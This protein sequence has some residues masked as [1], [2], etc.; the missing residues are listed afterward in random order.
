MAKRKNFEIRLNG[1]LLATKH[2]WNASKRE[3]EKLVKQVAIKNGAT[4]YNRGMC[5]LEQD[6][7]KCF[8]KGYYLW[9]CAGA[10]YQYWIE[11]V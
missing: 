7:Y 4:A 1:E 11:Q 8:V 3:V 6:D 10:I 5:N 2:A 9:E